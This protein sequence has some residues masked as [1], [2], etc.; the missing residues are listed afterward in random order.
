MPK[1]GEHHEEHQ[2]AMKITPQVWASNRDIPGWSSLNKETKIAIDRKFKTNMNLV[3]QYA[4]TN[5]GEAVHYYRNLNG[6]REILYA[7]GYIAKKYLG[8][9]K[10][11]ETI[12]GGS[13][14]NPD[15]TYV[16]KTISDYAKSY[17]LLQ[18]I[19]HRICQQ[20]DKPSALTTFKIDEVN[21]HYMFY[22]A[23][24][25]FIQIPNVGKDWYGALSE[26]CYL[27]Q[28]LL[29]NHGV[30]LWDLGFANGKNYMLDDNGKMRWVDYGGAGLVKTK[31]FN[32]SLKP[33]GDKWAPYE[34]VLKN[35][36]DN[37]QLLVDADN[38]FIR[39]A[40]F[41][42]LQHVIDDYLQKPTDNINVWMSTAQLNQSVTHEIY[43]DILP[44]KLQDPWVKE[45]FELF[46][47]HDFT[48]STTWKAMGK[49]ID[50]HVN[51]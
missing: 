20:E 5:S 44:N 35:T 17:I 29:Q 50:N 9:G 31:D 42:H 8:K 15:K 3:N 47:S 13:F 22:K 27:N 23:D 4:I 19:L 45:M 25:P 6:D 1:W 21:F 28:W 7:Y 10:D 49:Y 43:N 34:K 2:K 48:N 37:K 11:G 38:D 24:K 30:L 41:L 40:F 18:M 36:K 33:K 16:V 12:F 46:K 51:T 32:T 39:V 14:L 26:V